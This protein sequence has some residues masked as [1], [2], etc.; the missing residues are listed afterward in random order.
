[1][2]KRCL[3]LIV[4][5]PLTASAWLDMNIRKD[6]GVIRYPD[7]VAQSVP[8]EKI[9]GNVSQ[10]AWR[11]DQEVAAAM[12][13]TVASVVNRAIYPYLS[14]EPFGWGKTEADGVTSGRLN[15]SGEELSWWCDTWLDEHY[16]AFTNRDFTADSTRIGPNKS[17]DSAPVILT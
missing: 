10:Y 2:R 3:S 4:L 13:G 5:L 7:F 14:L 8:R 6:D 12:Y 1:M 11:L 17:N 16:Y 15:Y 9:P